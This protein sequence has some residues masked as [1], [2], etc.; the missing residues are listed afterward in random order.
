MAVR[1]NRAT[2]NRVMKGNRLLTWLRGAGRFK[3]GVAA[4]AA[5]LL[6][7]GTA[8]SA[9]AQRLQEALPDDDDKFIRWGIAAGVIVII[10]LPAFLNP[11]RSHLT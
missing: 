4:A 6:V 2:Y 10:A 7:H 11:K 5:L 9:Y 1:E 3:R 8:A